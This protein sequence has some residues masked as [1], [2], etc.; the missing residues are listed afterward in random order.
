[1]IKLI[2]S[3][4]DGTLLD[5]KQKI[6]PVN[7]QAIRQAQAAGICFVISTGRNYD[8]IEP[9]FE[10]YDFRCVS[11]LQNGAEI[12]DENGSI[13]SVTN[14][15]KEDVLTCTNILEA[16]NLHAEY[17]TNKGVYTIYS[18]EQAFEFMVDRMRCLRPDMSR[19]SLADMVPE[20]VFFKKLHYAEG[21]DEL[22]QQQFEIR[23]MITFHENPD[24]CR[25]VRAEL[26]VSADICASSSYPTNIEIN[27]KKAQKGI[28]LKNL[29]GTMGIKPEEVAVFGDGL[30]DRSL[31]TEFKNSYAP[32]NAVSEIQNLAGE[33]IGYHDEDAVGAK[34][35][36]F[37]R[38]SAK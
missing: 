25:S 37:L 35:L 38:R 23:K 8:T 2:A 36:S 20:T 17:M 6:S 22:M 11:L 24:V 21:I 3:D 29:I 31:F 32:K 16:H 14:M 33:I 15:K 26:E 7:L 12:R 19:A 9:M 10:E 4:L 18:K 30:N 1:M 34:I 27:H 5:K 28:A 13:L